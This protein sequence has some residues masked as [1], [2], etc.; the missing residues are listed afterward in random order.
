MTRFRFKVWNLSSLDIGCG[1]T[2]GHIKKGEIGI[3]LERGLCDV[4]ASAYYLPF[5]DFCFRKVIMSHI[6]EHL[7]DCDKALTE[8]TRV[9]TRKGILE[10]EVPN[11]HNF[12]IF[13]DILLRKKGFYEASK[14]H[15]YAFGEN[16]LRNVLQKLNFE[17]IKLEYVNSSGAEEKLKKSWLFKRAVHKWIGLVFPEF[18]TAIRLECRKLNVSGRNL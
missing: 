2:S 7:V 3:D 12:G 13:K 1:Y 17:I 18:K 5:R 6:L 15:I 16:E 10:I 9:L 8:V 14:D 11:P 4:L